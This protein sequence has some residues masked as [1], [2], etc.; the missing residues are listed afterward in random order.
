MTS[1]NVDATQASGPVVGH[2]FPFAVLRPHDLMDVVSDFVKEYLPEEHRPQQSESQQEGWGPG[3]GPI[4]KD[5][6]PSWLPFP[7]LVVEPG[8]ISMPDLSAKSA[9]PSPLP[10]TRQRGR[11][12]QHHLNEAN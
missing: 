5:L 3:N 10:Q 6:Y 12:R 1:A 11:V 2:V 4:N 7:R 8:G 9:R